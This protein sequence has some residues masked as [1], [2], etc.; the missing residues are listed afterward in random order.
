MAERYFVI[1]K[2]YDMVS[3]FVSTHAVKL[4]G[5]LSYK[6]PEGTHAIGRLDKNSE[7]LLILT[8]NKKVTRLLFSS[9]TPHKRVYM[10]QVKN[11]ISDQ[12]LDQLRIGINI[13]IKGGEKYITPACNVCVI[14]E[15]EALYRSVNSFSKYGQHTW[16]L[17]T[18]TEGKY[19]QVRKMI[20]AIHH[21][22]QRLIRI[23]I[24]DLLL[25]NLEPGQV[26]EIEEEDFFKKLKI[27]NWKQPVD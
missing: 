13:R 23:S 18:L 5:Q 7:G 25:D 1:N 17:I 2:P 14:D 8:T 26:R 6:F 12:K 9:L 27:E 11:I 19:H 4:L 10:V 15:P 3:Q 20:G 24:E 21:R 16:L 22:V